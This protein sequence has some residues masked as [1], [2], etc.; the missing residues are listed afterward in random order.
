MMRV[1]KRGAAPRRR[2][3]MNPDQVIANLLDTLER[4]AIALEALHDDAMTALEGVGY[5][6]PRN[7]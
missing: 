5:S 4:I 3:A 1:G 7:D 6:G 2:A